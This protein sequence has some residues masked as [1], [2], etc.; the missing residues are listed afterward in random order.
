MLL[1]EDPLV[2]IAVGVTQAVG[3]LLH[4]AHLV[5]PRV[6]DGLVI[7]G[8]QSC[9]GLRRREGVYL[10]V[11]EHRLREHRRHSGRAVH[12]RHRLPRGHAAQCVVG[13]GAVKVL[14]RGPLQ[15]DTGQ[16]VHVVVFKA[17]LHVG[18][19]VLSGG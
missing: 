3:A 2:V 11:V 18:Q 8:K 14:P 16:T 7:Q 12:R 13:H 9:C 10:G 15:R 19:V 4:L 1:H 17:F 6:G 5:K